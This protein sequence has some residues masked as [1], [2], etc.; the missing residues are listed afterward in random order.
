MP[1][2]GENTHVLLHGLHGKNIGYH[3]DIHS[4]LQELCIFFFQFCSSDSPYSTPNTR[5]LPQYKTPLCGS[6]CYWNP[7]T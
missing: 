5:F 2:L 1:S 3:S 4:F 7:S 6:A